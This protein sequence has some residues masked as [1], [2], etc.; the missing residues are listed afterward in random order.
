MKWDKHAINILFASNFVLDQLSESNKNFFSEIHVITRDMK[1]PNPQEI[2]PFI[3][4]YVNRYGSDNIR[5]LTNEDSTQILCANLRQCY[6]I[7]GW[8]RD[9]IMPYVSKIES[10]KQ[11]SGLVTMPRYQSFDKLQFL[12]NPE[13]YIL[14]IAQY[15]GFPAFIKPI[16][17]VSSLGTY[18]VNNE[19]EV[20]NVLSSIANCK[21]S[22][23]ID[24]FIDG[25]VLH[26]DVVLDHG[27]I[28][29]FGVGRNNT[30]LSLF[31]HGVPAGSL[32]ELE[33]SFIHK[34]REFSEEILTKLQANHGVFHLEFFHDDLHD[35]L[36]FLEIAARMGGSH[37]ADV[38]QKMYGF[39]LE[40]VCLAL[41]ADINQDFEVKNS[42]VT[43]AFINYPKKKCN[44]IEFKE[45]LI[46]SSFTLI[47]R[48]SIGDNLSHTESLLDSCASII[49]WNTSYS[50]LKKDFYELI[51]FDPLVTEQAVY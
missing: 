49:L 20:F 39:H 44:V 32:P 21:H 50:E 36:I 7:P 38:Y 28:K 14:K 6:G 46:D 8:G 24:E 27:V 29:F 42:Q 4:D 48:V 25:D 9:F 37:I 26:A 13:A 51:K 35:Q 3:A 12:E 30:P 1:Q 19:E 17:L 45:P 5:L 41:Q 16:D 10:K 33:N 22:Y 15:I 18:K 43:A 2:T 31:Q 23:E 47:K 40:D 34:A 11:L